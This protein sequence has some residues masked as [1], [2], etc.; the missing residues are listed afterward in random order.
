MT[1]IGTI[2]NQVTMRYG[3][4]EPFTP[5]GGNEPVFGLQVRKLG[6]L[7]AMDNVL[8]GAI[9]RLEQWSGAVNTST[10]T[11]S[12]YLAPTGS[13]T[14]AAGIT[15][16]FGLT[17]G[18]WYLREIVPPAGF[19]LLPD[20]IPV[21]I[22]TAN[23]AVPNVTANLYIVEVDVRNVPDFELPLT[24]GAGTILFTILGLALMGGAAILLIAVRKK[25]K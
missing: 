18:N 25:S 7:P 22:N 13:G 10:M 4:N 6:P 23:A 11:Y 12:R 14:F 8:D 17:Q 1:D 20:P 2:P 16:A 15:Q 9:F 3:P 21:T 24:G 19:L 5:P